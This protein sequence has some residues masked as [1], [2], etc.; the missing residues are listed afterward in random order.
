MNAIVAR[1]IRKGAREAVKKA[2]KYIRDD[3]RKAI[4]QAFIDAIDRI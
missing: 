3:Q 4:Y 1:L 2:I